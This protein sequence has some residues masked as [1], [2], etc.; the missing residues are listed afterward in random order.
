MVLPPP[1][2]MGNRQAQP[3]GFMMNLMG[4]QQTLIDVPPP[5]MLGGAQK[6]KQV[7]HPAHRKC[8]HGGSAQVHSQNPTLRI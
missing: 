5:L 2:M 7:Q 6:E 8:I 3:N 4:F 1:N